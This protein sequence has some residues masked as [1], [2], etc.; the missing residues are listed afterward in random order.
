VS[1]VYGVG[2]SLTCRFSPSC[3]LRSV[4]VRAARSSLSCRQSLPY[5]LLLSS[6]ALPSVR[7]LEDLL[8]ECTYLGLLE[9]QLNQKEAT[10]EIT[11]AIG[12]DIG[13]ND[14]EKMIARI[15]EWSTHTTHTPRTPRTPRTHTS[16]VGRA[17]APRHAMK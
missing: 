17:S 16:D 4:G 5:S 6:L 10:V 12:R 8:I 2:L 15:E 7:A 14:V 9:C 11:S 3:A 13:P 1:R